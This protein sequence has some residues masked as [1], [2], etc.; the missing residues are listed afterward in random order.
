MTYS[1]LKPGNVVR[2]NNQVWLVCEVSK[3]QVQL[4][5]FDNHKSHIRL[6]SQPPGGAVV[7]L[8]G[9][10]TNY[11]IGLITQNY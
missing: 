10:A 4:V 7:Y 11:V 3:R 5:A 8:A 6:N 9:N 2:Y 1:H